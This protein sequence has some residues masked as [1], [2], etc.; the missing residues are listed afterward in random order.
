MIHRRNQQS[1]LTQKIVFDTALHRA[2]G[3]RKA[4]VSDI[5]EIYGLNDKYLISEVFMSRCSQLTGNV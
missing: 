1:L 4:N 2:N 3:R 5:E